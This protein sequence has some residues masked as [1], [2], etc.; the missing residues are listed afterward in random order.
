[1]DKKYTDVMVDLETMG[2]S[3]NAAILSIGAVA[4]SFE[5]KTENLVEDKNRHFYQ[6]ISLR[7]AMTH[8]GVL[9]ADTVLWWLKQSDQARNQLTSETLPQ[10]TMPVALMDFILWIDEVSVGSKNVRIWGNGASFDNAILSD[11]YRRME[12]DQPWSYWNDRCYRTAK[13]SSSVPFVRLGTHHHALWDAV[14]QAAHLLKIR[15]E[16]HGKK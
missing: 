14:S 4:F 11:A 10:V 15:E 6:R 12:F 2:T 13:A 7:S 8:G 1:M 9:D 5:D 16:V 3:V